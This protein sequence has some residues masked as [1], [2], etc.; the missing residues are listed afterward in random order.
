MQVAFKHFAFINSSQTWDE[1]LSD[2][3]AF[4]TKVGR[5]RLIN[6]SQ[7]HSGGSR[8][9]SVFGEGGLGVVTVWY[10]LDADQAAL[11]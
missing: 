6:I 5:D 2:A 1:L 10:W 7:S 4:A 9:S 11:A 3:A 8:G